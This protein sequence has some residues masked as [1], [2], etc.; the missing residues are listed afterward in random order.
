MVWTPTV[1]LK[2]IPFFFPPLLRDDDFLLLDLVGLP[3]DPRLGVLG[4]LGDLLLEVDDRLFDS[5]C[6]GVS[7]PSATGGGGAG[8]GGSGALFF[9][10]GTKSGIMEIMSSA[11]SSAA[12]SYIVVI[13]QVGTTRFFVK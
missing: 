6:G 11:S 3:L 13:F 8:A 12:P 10:S 7:D 1:F 5:D 9:R 4:V 2:V